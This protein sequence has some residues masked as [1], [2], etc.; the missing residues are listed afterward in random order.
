MTMGVLEEIW[1]VPEEHFSNRGSTAVDAKFDTTLMIDICRQSRIPMILG[2]VDAAQCYDRVLHL[3]IVLML[4]ALLRNYLCALVYLCPMQLMKFFIRSGFGD[5]AAYYGG[6]ASIFAWMGLGQGSRGAPDGW[7]MVSSPMFN[8]LRK[9]RMCAEVENP[10]THEKTSS[11]GC[12]FVD[13]ATM[14]V[15]KKELDTAE[16]VYKEAEEH[17]SAWATLLRVTGGCPKS[18]KIF[19]YCIEPFYDGCKWVLAKTGGMPMEL[20]GDEGIPVNVESL[21]LDKEKK[22]LGVYDSPDGGSKTQLQKKLEKVETFV[23]RMNSG[24]LPSNLGWLSY[25]YKLWSSVRYGIGVMTNDIEEADSL[26]DKMDH[27]MMNI[28]GVASTIKKGWRRLHSVFGGI[29]L[30]NFVTEQLVERLNLLLQHYCTGSSLSCKLSASISFLQLQLGVNVC[31]LDLPYE[32]WHYM[33]PLSWVKMLWRTLQVTG[34]ELYLEHDPIPFPRKGDSLIIDR[35]RELSGNNPDHLVK[36]ARV[37]GSLGVIF[38]SDIVTAD[39]KCVEQFA[40]DRFLSPGIRRSTYDFP[41]E[42]PTESDWELWVS[43][44]KSMTGENFELLTPLGA[45]DEIT[46]RDWEWKLSEDGEV[47][48]QRV[49]KGW[50]MHVR[51]DE[52]WLSEGVTLVPPRGK[53]AS[54]K[55]TRAGKIVLRSSASMVASRAE[56]VYNSFWEVL[57]DMGGEWMWENVPD[58]VKAEDFTWTAEGL[59]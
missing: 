58:E 5:S 59:T 8:I 11:V 38:M 30:Y 42:M 36:L 35:L 6:L 1:D 12:A 7:L 25:R 18:K 13:D 2:S 9:E 46:H 47:L 52:S 41:K 14:Y 20:P 16:K 27:K 49:E 37:R 50:L 4:L 19:W 32:D 53:A 40:V 26:L 17:M 56:K 54:V 51:Q 3:F 29:G 15:Y 45:W 33:A 10:I 24:K 48:Y 23:Q 31:P 57:D 39:G 43:Y 21:P 34:F 28:L 55:V 44:L 22:L